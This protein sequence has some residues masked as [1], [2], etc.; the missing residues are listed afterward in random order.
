[1]NEAMLLLRARAYAEERVLLDL[2]KDV[3]TRRVTFY[4]D[5]DHDG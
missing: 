4:P 2:A 5:E 3:V 1:M